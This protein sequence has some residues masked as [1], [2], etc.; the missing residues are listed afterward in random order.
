MV[1]TFG[2]PVLNRMEVWAYEVDSAA[3]ES[4]PAAP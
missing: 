4:E 2:G 1:T 3:E